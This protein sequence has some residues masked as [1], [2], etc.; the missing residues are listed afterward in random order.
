MIS[1]HIKTFITETHLKMS[2]CLSAHLAVVPALKVRMR[3][4]CQ[5]SFQSPTKIIFCLESPL[6]LFLKHK[7]DFKGPNKI[8][9]FIN[10]NFRSL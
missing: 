5:V 1:Y 8:S 2:P 3:L 10:G 6:K 4:N 9:A 7:E